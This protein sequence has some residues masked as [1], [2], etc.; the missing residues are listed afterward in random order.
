[1]TRFTTLFLLI[2]AIATLTVH[3]SH[4]F[5]DVILDAAL[6]AADKVP[7]P[8]SHPQRWDRRY[9]IKPNCPTVAGVQYDNDGLY[10]VEKC[11]PGWRG[12]GVQ[13]W[14][15]LHVYGKGCC[16]TLFTKGCCDNCNPG[17]VDDGCT[18]RRPPQSRK[19][20][21]FVREKWDKAKNVVE[22]A[23]PPH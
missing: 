11:P 9:C 1:M 10:C 17:Y 7:C 15:D 4:A 5:V 22:P 23:T 8:A 13:C 18:C 16:C 19:Q 3:Q 20:K 14:L 2:A 6:E 12:D 21:R